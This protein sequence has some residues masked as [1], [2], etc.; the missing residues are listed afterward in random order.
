M[1]EDPSFPSISSSASQEGH[2]NRSGQAA[3]RKLKVTLLSSEWQSTK[4]GLSTINRELAIQLAK[5]QNVEVSMYLPQCSE[6]DVK[7]A[8]GY[9]VKL[10]QAKKLVGYEPIEWLSC[11]PENHKID[12]VIGHGL[13][14][15][16]Q[17]QLIQKQLT[18]KWVQ[19]VHTAP[20]DL[21]MF[22]KYANA[23]SRAEEKHKAEIELCELADEVVAIG[24]KL[25]DEYSRYLR[26]CRR[27]QSVFEVTPSIFSEFSPVK[28][29]AEERRTFC[30]LVFGRGDNEDFEL[31]GYDIA[32]EAFSKLKKK[33]LYQLVFVGAPLGREEEVAEKLCQ[34]GVARRQ[35][36]VR[37]FKESREDL[38]RLFCEVDLCIMPSRT[39]GFGLAALEALSAGLPILVSG[40]S[41]FGDAL[42]NV[43]HGSSC[44]VNSE[45]PKEWARAIKI[46]CKKRRD[47]RLKET[48]D[49]C[50]DYAEEYS[51]EKQCGELVRR[52]LDATH[53]ASAGEQE[54]LL[55][56]SHLP[57]AMVCEAYLETTDKK[58]KRPL[59]PSVTPT[60]KKQRG[61]SGIC[62]EIHHASLEEEASSMTSS[63]LPTTVDTLARNLYGGVSERQIAEMQHDTDNRKVDSVVVK[64]LRE[65]YKRRAEFRPL[66]WSK[67]MKLHLDEVYTRLKIV[68]RRKG[69]GHF[70]GSEIDL[71]N[72]FDCTK[73]DSMALAEGSP[74][75]GKTTL[76]LKLAYDWATES[77]P[78]TFPVLEL[79]L[80]LKCRD[81]DGD[82]REAIFQQ[83]LPEDIQIKTKERL[84]NFMRDFINQDRILIIL[85]GLDELPE[86]SKNDVDSLLGR[87]ILP[88]CYVFTTTRQEKGIEARKNFL[89]DICFQIEGFNEK[90]SHE[91]VRK[92]FKNID[93]SKGESLV[94]EIKENTLLH[95]LQNNPLNLLLVCVVYEDHEGKLPSS[96]TNLYQIIVGCLLRRYCFKHNVEACEED[97]DLENQFKADILV[98]GELAWKCLL[99]DRH[100][101]C[102]ESLREFERSN[103]KLVVRYLGLVYKEES[104]KRL[105]P[106]H[107]YRFL[108]KSFQEY[109]AASY[110][111]H[112]LRGKPFNVFEDV[113]Q[114][115]QVA[116][117]FPQVFLFVCGILREEASIL[118]IQ[119]GEKLKSYRQWA[120]RA[121]TVTNFFFESF[122]ESGNPERMADALFS[123]I[124]FPRV[125]HLCLI[126]DESDEDFSDW[127]VARVLSA[128]TRFSK[129][130]IPAEVHAAVTF[131]SGLTF[132]RELVSVPN[133]KSLHFSGN[134]YILGQRRFFQ[135]ISNFTSLSALTLPSAVE[136]EIAAKYLT[137]NKTLEKVTFALVNE[138]DEGWAK[139][140]EAGLCADTPLSSVGVRIHGSL[141][142]TALQALKNLLF[143]RFLSSLAIYICGDMQ[144]SLAVA[145]T[146]GL[147]GQVAV[148][149][150]DLC[151]NGKLSLHGAN[152]IERVIV[153]NNSRTKLIVSLR[154]EVPDNWQ[155]VGR[156]IHSRLGGE[157]STSFALYP[158][159]FGKVT[160]SQVT[161][162]CPF[163]ITDGLLVQQN[164]TLNVWGEL[165]R[166]G[167][168]ALFRGL[169]RSPVSHLTFDIHGKLTDDILNSTA[170]W[171]DERK[172]LSSLTINTWERLSKEGNA[173][174]EELKL[175]KNSAVTVNV[176]DVP[177]PPEESLDMEYV[178][179]DNL[180]S[181]TSVFEEAKNSGQRNLSATISIYSDDAKDSKGCLLNVFPR[182]ETL[183][184]SD[185]GNGVD[186]GAAS[187]TSLIA[188]TPE[189][190]KYTNFS[191]ELKGD[192]DRILASNTTLNDLSLTFSDDNNMDHAWALLLEY[193][194]ACNTSLKN[195]TLTINCYG[196]M[197]ETWK[198]SVCDGLEGNTSLKNLS[199]IVENHSNRLVDDLG[200]ILARN[201]SVENFSLTV[202]NHLDSACVVSLGK[203]GEGLA[204]SKSLKNLTL[205]FNNFSS[206]LFGCES[207]GLDINSVNDASLKINN[208][209]NMLCDRSAF[210]NFLLSFQ[211]LTTLNLTLDSR[212]EGDEEIL[213]GLLEAANL[214]ESLETLR[215]KVNDP[216]I[217]TDS[218]G[219][220]FSKFVVTSPSLS[221]I[222]VSVSLYGGEESS[223]K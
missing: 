43:P 173:L 192:L 72:I 137:T 58:G 146:R 97:R 107:E 138:S 118:F 18:C 4:G 12:Y 148:K 162:C 202:I 189:N 98:L 220:D 130:Q 175:D 147:A 142:P 176:S 3:S 45:D 132:L 113:D 187:N 164:F 5:H 71:G 68:S 24:P 79:V 179:I 115:L 13:I 35:L 207:K 180:G 40:N 117:K 111:A 65:E 157:R 83:L 212:G 216:Q 104:L 96:R 127:H 6:E 34:H 19:V 75:I 217:T 163:E 128:C 135:E 26:H 32:A 126:G 77:L 178:S 21:G 199:L 155:A 84:V 50:I 222:E 200:I 140:L 36:T 64:L 69:G 17:V 145:L 170:R 122:R 152:L 213:P 211:S 109:L 91:Y 81:F 80:L 134:K 214:S 198:R 61:D 205:T 129:I 124:P 101:F 120:L 2:E 67:A 219:Y 46:V 92:H 144:D 197:N 204:Y 165:G 100:S 63:H 166:D 93:P 201:T 143:N 156:N 70:R 206:M 78:S 191:L 74:G 116:N 183:K 22:K 33:P 172:T 62:R 221:L 160:A 151:V 203:L 133:L 102:E 90:D 149:V 31:K 181:L 30:V 167:A 108:H 139:A 121:K 23:I 177:A 10:I 188:L 182:K 15:G 25:A 168:E 82:M 29:A 55:T 131:S 56:R 48:K 190:I 209:G 184:N 158:N 215:L 28:Q 11:A 186:A 53:H 16:R 86:N 9:H 14:L 99:S 27:D 85:D 73:N 47:V 54:S 95:A 150:V 52:M 154:G 66:L 112:K 161:Q 169:S 59:H 106:R 194:L 193:G 123:Y 49:L 8:E 196:K 94:E 136:W 41:G 88:F 42:Q 39:E 159:T 57:T 153:E 51:W 223:R 185:L 76:C 37:S 125:V 171:V 119:I 60:S 110:I 7:I 195:L 38:I 1:S 89:F 20:E 44:V 114:F 141:R 103:D 174:F 208:Y 105:K 87:R 218:G 210:A